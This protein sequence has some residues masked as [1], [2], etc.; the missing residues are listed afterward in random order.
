MSHEEL[1]GAPG[2]SNHPGETTAGESREATQTS[3][4]APKE[5]PT[6][7]DIQRFADMLWAQDDPDVQQKFPGKYVAVH[8]RQILAVGDDLSAVYAE[9]EA[10]SGLSRSQIALAVIDDDASFLGI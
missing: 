7:E 8:Q 2:L 5:I 1:S 4:M 9:A 10:K 3:P 6:E